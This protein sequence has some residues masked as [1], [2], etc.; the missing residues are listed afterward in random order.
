MF[1]SPPHCKVE[2][3]GL[4]RSCTQSR[5]IFLHKQKERNMAACCRTAT[6]CCNHIIKIYQCRGLQQRTLTYFRVAGSICNRLDDYRITNFS[7]TCANS[8][9]GDSRIQKFRKVVDT[10][11]AGSK[12]LGKDVKLMFEIQ[13]RLKN[14]NY[15]WDMLKTEEIIH[16][17]QVG[18]SLHP[19]AGSSNMYA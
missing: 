9:R 8:A 16:L 15:D 14:N 19:P 1:P 2:A 5:S 4:D 6:Q 11:V 18:Q 17:H 10:F 13:K 7:T 12:Q 3:E